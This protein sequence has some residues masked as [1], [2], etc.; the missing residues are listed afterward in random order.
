MRLFALPLVLCSL[1]AAAARADDTAERGTV[2]FEPKDDQK[3]IP[4]RYRLGPHS[5]DYEMKL[6]RTLP[7]SKIDIFHLTFPSPVATDCVENNTVHAEYYRP[8]VK[9]PMPCV[10]VLDITGGN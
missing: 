10:V 5:F 8:Q 2:R 4:E 7:Q 6:Q 3:N 1:C 9:T